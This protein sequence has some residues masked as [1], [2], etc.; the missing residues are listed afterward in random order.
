MKKEFENKVVVV[1]GGA[2]GIGLAIARS[3]TREGALVE[4]IDKGK[5]IIML[6]I[7]A[8]KR[9]WRLLQPKS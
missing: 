6:G 4:V 1:T 9:F 5:A 2:H 3:F 7:S 8:K